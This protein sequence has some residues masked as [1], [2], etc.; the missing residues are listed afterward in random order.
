MATAVSYGS[1]CE[2][3][4]KTLDQRFKIELGRNVSYSVRPDKRMDPHRPAL[5]VLL[6]KFVIS[7]RK[8]NYWVA[9]GD[10]QRGLRAR[11]EPQDLRLDIV[12][13]DGYHRH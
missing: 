3:C 10:H 6:A 2:R 5:A 9:A 8:R 7:R 1:H 13:E 4:P 12:Y 11:F